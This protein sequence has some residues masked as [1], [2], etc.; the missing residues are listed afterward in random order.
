ME[1]YN[2]STAGSNY[3]STAYK[4]TYLTSDLI[5]YYINNSSK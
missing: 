3:L 5:Y 4:I 1:L 2:I